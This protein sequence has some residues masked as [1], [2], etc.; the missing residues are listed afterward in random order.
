MTPNQD[1]GYLKFE[2]QWNQA[3]IHIPPA[4]L[5][6]L[7]RWRDQLY[8]TGLIGAYPDGIG[9]G[10][11]SC[12]VPGSGESP[13]QFYITGSATGNFEHLQEENY[14]LVT[15]YSLS[16]NTLSC[17][18]RTKASS[19][20]LSHAAIYEAV[21]DAQAVIHIH[22]HEMWEAYCDRFPTTPRD[23]PYGTPE[24]AFALRGLAGSYEDRS[25][26]HAER[27]IIMGG[28]EDGVVCFGETLAEA[29]EPL[30]RLLRNVSDGRGSCET[31]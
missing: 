15:G 30:L 23:T 20:S 6:E 7:E 10:N 26:A 27:V 18:G 1:E 31:T 4:L 25:P 11:V 14:A 13:A 17:T 22:H 29:G 2:L 24:M 9:F 12:R 16:Q 5:R 21:P 28:H 3:A 19:E 8:A